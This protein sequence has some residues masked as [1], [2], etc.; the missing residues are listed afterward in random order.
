MDAYLT[1]L[2]DII[3][4][5]RMDN[6]YKMAWARSIVERCERAPK[7]EI[8]FDELARLIFKYYWNQTIFFD[9]KQGPS[10]G[11]RPEIHRMVLE[12]ID[13]FQSVE[14]VRPQTFLK[15]A[16]KVDI[17]VRQISRILGQDVCERFLNVSPKTYDIYEYDLDAQLIRLKHPELIKANADVLYQLINYRWAQKLE[18]IDGSPR[19][20]KK[21][22]GVDSEQV[23][24]RASL[25]KFKKYLD[26]E[27]P[28]KKCFF[29]GSTILE[30]Q[31]SIDHVIPWSYMYSDDL[32]NLVYLDKR[33]N[34]SKNNTLPTE[35]I[36]DKLEKRNSKLLS[37][38]Q[39]K[40]VEDKHV[41]D[42]KNAIEKDY[43]RR[44]WIGF[45]G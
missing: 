20:A 28:H 17:P 41:T 38:L 3:S 18:D 45:K 16:H 2:I 11:R 14:G 32:W 21:I 22:R 34:S 6:T 15:I 19:L 30:D 9:L 8:H 35:R 10:L 33:Q 44:Y 23:P 42:L 27:N 12:Q 39:S 29:S 24:K 37:L 13:R 7:K 4:N 1:N 5:G 25:T 36:I 40:G 26:L 31:I 43:V